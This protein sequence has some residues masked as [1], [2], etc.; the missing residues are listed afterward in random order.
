MLYKQLQLRNALLELV[1]CLQGSIVHGTMKP[2]NIN[3]QLAK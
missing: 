1:V 2:K 3:V